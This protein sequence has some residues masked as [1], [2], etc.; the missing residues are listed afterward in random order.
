MTWVS[1]NWES[2]LGRRKRRGEV[3]AAAAVGVGARPLAGLNVETALNV[4]R[5]R[6][7]LLRHGGMYFS[8]QVN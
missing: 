3:A 6:D 4:G 5:L 1:S 8:H 2:G 7:Q